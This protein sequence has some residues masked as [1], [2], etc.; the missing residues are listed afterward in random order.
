[1]TGDHGFSMRQD[2]G[3]TL[4]KHKKIASISIC[5][6]FYGTR[7]PEK[8]KRSALLHVTDIMCKGVAL[9]AE[10]LS[11]FE[12]FK[13]N[14]DLGVFGPF[15]VTGI[16]MGGHMAALAGCNSLDP[17]AVIPCLSPF[18]AGP[19]FTEGLLRNWCAWKELDKQISSYLSEDQRDMESK[20]YLR[21][22]L[23]E[24]TDLTKFPKPRCMEATIQVAAKYDSYVPPGQGEYYIT[25]GKVRN[26]GGRHTLMSPPLHWA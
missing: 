12:Y 15:G 10:G 1:M 26:C 2:I 8:Q 21:Y 7:K 18:S 11:L 4:L 23:D 25:T 24:T 16:S 5:N 14:K 20:E 19:V 13:L 9:V 6:P 22:L 17:I 3:F